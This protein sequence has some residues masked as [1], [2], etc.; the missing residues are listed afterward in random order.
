MAEPIGSFGA[1]D[2]MVKALAKI[3]E[4]GG[5]VPEA[6]IENLF[7]WYDA[8]GSLVLVRAR[9]AGADRLYDTSD[10]VVIDQRYFAHQ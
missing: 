10:D 7:A 2:E 8:K 5:D 3:S 6:A 9:S 4:A 1:P